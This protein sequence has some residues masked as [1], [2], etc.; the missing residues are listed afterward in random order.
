MSKDI[1]KDLQFMM[2]NSSHPEPIISQAIQEIRKLYLKIAELERYKD[3][4]LRIKLNYDPLDPSDP[5]NPD[6]K[7]LD[8]LNDHKEYVT[9]FAPIW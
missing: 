4:I 6:S 2:N 7:R 3:N 1:C 8:F 5:T 9:G